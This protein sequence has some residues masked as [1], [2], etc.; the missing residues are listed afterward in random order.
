MVNNGIKILYI[1]KNLKKLT[2]LNLLSSFTMARTR[3][4]IKR[5]SGKGH[6]KNFFRKFREHSHFS[7]GHTPT[8]RLL[9]VSHG[10][11]IENKELRN[12][13]ESCKSLGAF[14][15]LEIDQQQQQINQQQQQ[16][17]QLQE[18]IQALLREKESFRLLPVVSQLHASQTKIQQVQAELNQKETSWLEERNN[19]R[20]II[21][22]LH[23]AE[24]ELRRTIEQKDNLI[25]GMQEMLRDRRR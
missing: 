19:T 17:N 10:L 23:A 4:N 1:R 21:S 13:V 11:Y 9:Q 25:R 2:K 16:I 22:D 8:Q 14:K 20:E 18:Q 5:R 12:E 24:E 3:K 6:K 15:L 7:P